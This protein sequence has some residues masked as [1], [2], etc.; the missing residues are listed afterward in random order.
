MEE[1]PWCN[2]FMSEQSP[3]FFWCKKCNRILRIYD[4]G[5]HIYYDENEN[6]CFPQHK[7]VNEIIEKNER[8]LKE[9]KKKKYK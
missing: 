1:C 8:E 6:V 9:L 4:G 2:I 7:N 5:A 3:V